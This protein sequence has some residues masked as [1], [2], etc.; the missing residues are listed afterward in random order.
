MRQR[1]RRCQP[2]AA[3]SSVSIAR[4]RVTDGRLRVFDEHDTGGAR[5]TS[6]IDAIESD[7]VVEEQGLRFAPL[8]GRI[9]G[10]AIS[11]EARADRAS[12]R[13]EFTAPAIADDDMPAALALLGSARPPFLRLDE[14]ASLFGHR[15]HR[16]RS[17]SPFREGHAPRAGRHAGPATRRRL[18]GAV[19]DRRLAPHVRADDIHP[20][21]GLPSRNRVDTPRRQSSAV[22]NRQ[23][24]RADRSGLVSRRPGSPRR[25]A[26][27]HGAIRRSAQ[28]S[29]RRSAR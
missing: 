20:L 18:R 27:R 17:V 12:V 16:S 15:P 22:V 2:P 1:S 8:R 7:I 4:V 25:A 10:A 29:A 13:L 11:G 21:R 24:C 6:S 28:R 26:R 23:P 9:R 14:P 5:E 19:R 3:G